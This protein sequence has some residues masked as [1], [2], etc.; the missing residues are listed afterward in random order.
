MNKGFSVFCVRLSAMFFASLLFLF[1]A[2]CALKYSTV[3][4]EDRILLSDNPDASGVYTSGPLTVGYQYQQSGD[5]LTISGNIIFRQSVDSLD[6]RMVFLD[7]A[8]LIVDRKLIYSSGYRSLTARDSTRTF[9]RSLLIP[10]GA[11]TFSFTES[12]VVRASRR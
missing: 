8:G 1:V 7:A 2:G 11:V 9:R 10:S 4:E 3:A 5:T 12:S 6:V